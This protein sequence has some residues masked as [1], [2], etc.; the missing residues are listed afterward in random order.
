MP[1]QERISFIF[2]SNI[3]IVV[4]TLVNISGKEQGEENLGI[5][6]L[7]VH[8]SNRGFTV[9]SFLLI[10]L[11]SSVLRVRLEKM[12]FFKAHLGIH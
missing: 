9:S 3:K 1:P 7:E 5:I 4:I 10:F 11:A 6:K 12:Y 2:N 8:V